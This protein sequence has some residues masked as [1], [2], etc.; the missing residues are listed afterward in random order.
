M[1]RELNL[2][3]HLLKTFVH[4]L[5]V[6]LSAFMDDKLS[7]SEGLYYGCFSTFGSNRKT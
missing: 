5:S 4:A 3:S 2:G 1:L 7:M 6:E